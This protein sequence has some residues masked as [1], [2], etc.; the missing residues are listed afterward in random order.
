MEV[1]I[2]QNQAN[3]GIKTQKSL[4]I[5]EQTGILRITTSS[6]ESPKTRKREINGL[7]KTA[8]A[9]R[10]T[11]LTLIT[12]STSEEIEVEGLKIRVIGAVDWL[13]K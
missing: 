13:T 5:W 8:K 10:C 12:F 2:L 4:Q 1:A 9:L 11:N 6:K 7:V 3:M